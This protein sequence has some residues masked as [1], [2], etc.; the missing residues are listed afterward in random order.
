MTPVAPIMSQFRHEGAFTFNIKISQNYCL[1]A[2]SIHYPNPNPCFLYDYNIVN[3]T[4]VLMSYYYQALMT[5]TYKNNK[6][7]LQL[8]TETYT[9]F[10]GVFNIQ[11]SL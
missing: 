11:D 8:I 9:C 2:K 5:H 1:E 4:S 6:M 3:N 10:T 7:A